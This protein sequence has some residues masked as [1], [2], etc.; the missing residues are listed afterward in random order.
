[1]NRRVGLIMLVLVMAVSMTACSQE[2][3]ITI[4]SKPMTEQFVIA[5]MLT[6]LIEQETDIKVELK[7][8]VGGGTS[9][10][11][12]A[13]ISGEIDIYPEYT[14]TGWMFVL[15]Q[16]LI[17]DPD[18]LY[19]EVKAGYKEEFDIVW[20]GLYGFNDTYGI[21]MKRELAEELG[22]ETYSDL[23][24]A[25]D[26][27][28]FGAEH[29]FFEREDGFPGLDDVYGFDFKKETGM[30]IG[31]K[32][33]AIESGEV[34]VINIFSTDGKLKEYDMVVLE[35]DEYFFPSYYAATLIRQETLDEYPELEEVIAMLDGQISNEEMTNMNYLVEIEK[36][37]PKQVALDFLEEKGLLK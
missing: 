15:E 30:D 20:S 5:E 22:I 8:G 17:N 10:I 1:M 12:P 19:E 27:L 36:M 32:Y 13:M 25:S 23:A 4:A 29:D 9:N 14:G 33:L 11:H 21:A 6:A 28:V 37:E 26:K 16:E 31:L 34:D 35:D 7:S 3:T 18:E 24:A 2:K